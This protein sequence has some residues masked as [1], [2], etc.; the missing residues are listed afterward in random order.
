MGATA[1]PTKYTPTRSRIKTGKSI[2]CVHIASDIT[3]EKTLKEQLLHAEKVTSIG[4]FVAGI[5]HE[6]N[7]PLM[8]IMGFSQILMNTTSDKSI[9]DPDIQDKLQKIYNE[10]L[11][12]AKIVQNL[13]TFSRSKKITKTGNNLNAL[14]RETLENRDEALKENNIEISLDLDAEIPNSMLDHYQIEQVFINIVNNAMEAMAE[15]N[16]GGTLKIIYPP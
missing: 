9:S 1:P 14:I 3:E 11:R 10:S 4:K 7:N 15:A 12:S 5:A 8:G 13:L 2:A 6:L 16:K